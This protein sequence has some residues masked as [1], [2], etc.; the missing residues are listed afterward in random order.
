MTEQTLT[1]RTARADSLR[2]VVGLLASRQVDV[3][4]LAATRSDGP[5]P[6]GFDIRLTVHLP[7]PGGA[8]LLGRRLD[9]LVDVIEVEHI[10]DAAA[11]CAAP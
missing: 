7:E 8:E 3:R 6:D 11:T 2:A 10:T 5:G 1:I 4:A 9:R